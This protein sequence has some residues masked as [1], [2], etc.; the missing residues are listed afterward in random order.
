MKKLEEYIKKYG[1]SFVLAAI[2]FGEYIRTVKSDKI[3]LD[4]GRANCEEYINDFFINIS[5]KYY[6]FLY[7]LT[8][9]NIVALFNIIMN[10][11]IFS[12]FLIVLSI[13]LSEQVIN[14]I[15]FLE[16]YPKIFNL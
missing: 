3:Y 11:L 10:G 1:T 2:T 8:P 13:M 12:S 4:K 7:I 6:E 14:R 16:K 5:E 9:E 15:K